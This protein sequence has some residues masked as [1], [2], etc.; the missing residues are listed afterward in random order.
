[1][2]TSAKA[3]IVP[4]SINGAEL[5]MPAGWLM[6]MQPSRNVVRVI[7]GDPIDCATTAADG[8]ELSESELGE[9]VKGAM[10][11]NLSE[12]QREKR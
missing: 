5:V 8:K 10:E 11:S 9:V 12:K 1:M 6:P 3:K 2:A 7:I 4:I